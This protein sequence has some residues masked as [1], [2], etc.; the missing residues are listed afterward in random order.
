MLE[1]TVNKAAS[2]EIIKAYMKLYNTLVEGYLTRGMSNGCAWYN[3]TLAMRTIITKR[4]GKIPDFVF[5]KLAEIF[6]THKQTVSKKSMLSEQKDN[7]NTTST[8]GNI[9]Q[10]LREF[11]KTLHDAADKY[12]MTMITA[13]PIIK[14]HSISR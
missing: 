9:R 11:D 12:Y 6:N 5:T 14:S 3:A 7:K 8:S 4:R 13:T 2:T 10:T 1:K